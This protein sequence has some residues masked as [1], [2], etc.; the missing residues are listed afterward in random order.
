MPAHWFLTLPFHSFLVH[1]SLKNWQ[2]SAPF[3]LSGIDLLLF[4]PAPLNFVTTNPKTM[5]PTHN[6]ILWALLLGLAVG[7]KTDSEGPAGQPTTEVSL[8]TAQAAFQL[9]EQA[10]A[11]TNTSLNS[12]A[13]YLYQA[14]ALQ[15]TLTT[16][17][18]LTEGGS[19]LS[20]APQP[21]DALVVQNNA[22]QTL[23]SF[24]YQTIEGNLS[25]DDQTLLSNDHRF[26]YRVEV[27]QQGA[28]NVQSVQAGGRRTIQ[29][30]GNLLYEGT[31]YQVDL[32]V[33]GTYFF[34][35]G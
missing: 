35:S 31:D 17:G 10:F 19:G 16:S 14:S 7:C 5:I 22:G 34:R 12:A 26:A 29:I 24:T 21:A 2:W 25:G 11:Q 4:L 15:G 30:N 32:L 13:F 3:F 1:S 27:P 20:Y 28:L 8:E 18:T 23:A 6:L 9:P 33:D